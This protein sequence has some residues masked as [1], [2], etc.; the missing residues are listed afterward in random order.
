MS[1]VGTNDDKIR[2]GAKA[3]ELATKACQLTN[4]KNGDAIDTLAAA[5]AEAGQ[6]EQAIRH[7]NQALEVPAFERQSG[8]AA[9]KRLRL[10][11]EGKP[12]RE[13]VMLRRRSRTIF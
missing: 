8:N 3:V 6:F 4:W 12:Y 9:R 7:E 11:E 10:Y 2:N 5:C 13:K 1:G